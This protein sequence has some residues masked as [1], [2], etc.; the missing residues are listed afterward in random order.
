MTDN[1][2]RTAPTQLKKPKVVLIDWGVF[3]FRAVYASRMNKAVPPTYTALSMIIGCLKLVGLDPDDLVIVAVD[4]RNSWRKDVDPEYKANRKDIRDKA[5]DID[6]S[7]Q[8][9]QFDAL[10]DNLKQATP[11]YPIRIH[12]L[13]ADDIIAVAVRYFKDRECIII[14]CD[15]DYEQLIAYPN[16]KVFSD[17]SKKYKH[18]PNPYKTLAKKMEKEVSDN[19]TSPIV[20]EEDYKRREKIVSLLE[21]PAEVEEAARLQLVQVTGEKEY[22]LLALKFGGIRKRFMDIYNS[23]NIVSYDEC[24]EEKPKAKKKRKKGKR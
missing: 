7:A 23:K 18:V 8:F 22:N 24:M 19:L 9:L 20:T 14:S 17:R 6:W 2:T 3:L 12:R 10:I 13:E 5:T 4:G 1:G 21:L 15:S 11:F 16:V